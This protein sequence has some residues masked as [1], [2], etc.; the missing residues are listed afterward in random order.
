MQTG[1]G[2]SRPS[3]R[4]TL[5]LNTSII[6]D[7]L[8]GTCDTTHAS[9]C[10]L[11]PGR[12]LEPSDEGRLRQK[13]F[14]CNDFF[15]CRSY[16]K[17]NDLKILNLFYEVNSNIDVNETRLESCIPYRGAHSSLHLSALS[18]H[19]DQHK[20]NVDLS[21]CLIKHYTVKTYGVVEV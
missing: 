3:P 18:S 12:F 2:G 14:H 13:N 15:T 21:P 19:P 6:P 7:Q 16:A 9:S 5:A 10:C 4:L 1:G 20:V 11:C 8:Q 17:K